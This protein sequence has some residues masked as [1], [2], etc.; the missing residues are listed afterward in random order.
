MVMALPGVRVVCQRPAPIAPRCGQMTPLEP[1]P[2]YPV[3]LVMGV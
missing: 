2:S 3:L 1:T